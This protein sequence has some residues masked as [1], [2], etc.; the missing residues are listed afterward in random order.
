ML[1][2][3][4][5][6]MGRKGATYQALLADEVN[7]VPDILR[8]ASSRFEGPCEFGVERYISEDFHRLEV[9]RMWCRTW[10][11]ACRETEIPKPGDFHVYEVAMI[12]ILIV[13]TQDNEIM[14]FRNACPHRGRRLKAAGGRGMKEIRCPFHGLHWDLDGQ[15]KGAPCAW[16][17]THVDPSK[18]ALHRISVGTWGG[19][20][21]INV[22]DKA[23][24][25]EAYL[26]VLSDHFSRWDP[27]N[28]YKAI[29]IAK[30]LPC[31]WKVAFEAFAESHHIVATHPQIMTYYGDA[32]SQYDLYGANVSRTISP[33]GISSP[34]IECA[35]PD[36]IV[37]EWL[38][39]TGRLPRG[40]KISVPDGVSAR[41]YL[42]DMFISQYSYMYKNDIS[43]TTTRSEVLDAIFYS[44]FPNF[45]PWAGFGPNLVYRFKPDGDSVREC[46]MEIMMMVTCP[47]GDE[48]P[49]DCKIHELEDDQGFGD[50]QEL[51]GLGRIIDQDVQNLKYVQDGLESL[52]GRKVVFSDYQEVRIRA[53]HQTLDRYVYGQP[54]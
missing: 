43:A 24:P 2:G 49:A 40:N 6:T 9:E 33:L 32:I 23:Q 46:V 42:A 17:F 39:H 16:D 15:F 3:I 13:R 36:K 53:F 48:R 51:M 27:A 1:S 35:N 45:M 37:N 19:W 7:P 26:G 29:H 20:V 10:Q 11:V 30:R 8:E 12:S 34:H 50:A 4:D 44:L 31:N 52:K 54:A 41:K 5:R 21:F 18:L 25:L 38:R 22:D 47:K 14:A 28:R